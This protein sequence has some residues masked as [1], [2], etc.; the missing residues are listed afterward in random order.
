M[1]TLGLHLLTEFSFEYLLDAPEC[2]S[3]NFGLY[4][5]HFEYYNIRLSFV[6]NPLEKNFVV[7]VVLFCLL[8]FF[9]CNLGVFRQQFLSPLWVQISVQLAKCLHCS[10]GVPCTCTIHG[11][12][13]DLGPTVYYSS[14][15]GYRF[16]SLLLQVC[17]IF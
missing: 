11:L 2:L 9:F 7:M 1:G 4:F 17:C 3:S 15:I 10:L 8:G 16:L 5:I 14:V 12:L 13:W 6:T